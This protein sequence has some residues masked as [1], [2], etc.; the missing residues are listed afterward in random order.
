MDQIKFKDETGG[1]LDAAK[2]DAKA[3]KMWLYDWMAQA[4]REKLERGAK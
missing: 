1:L 4:I 2:A 3:R